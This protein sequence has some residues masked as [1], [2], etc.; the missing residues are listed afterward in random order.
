MYQEG[1]ERKEDNM[2]IGPMVFNLDA[3]NVEDLRILEQEV[4]RKRKRKTRQAEYQLRMNELLKEAH[5]N[6]FTFVDVKCGFVREPD[7]FAIIDE[8]P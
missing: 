5:D 7:D 2:R 1:T 6:G 8:Q 4:H 3:L